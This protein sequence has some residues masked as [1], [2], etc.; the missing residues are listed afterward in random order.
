[1]PMVYIVDDEPHIRR[2]AAIGLKDA[3]FDTAEFSDGATLLHAMRQA[4]PDAVLLDWMLPGQDGINVLRTIRQDSSMRPTPILMMTA[5]SDEVD[6]VLG[7]EFGADDYVTKPFS[8]KE[9][10][11]RVKAV[12][13]RNEYLNTPQ[14]D[15]LSGGGLRVDNA[16]RSVTKNGEPVEL[17]QREFDLLY[18]LM[19][20]P[21]RVFTREMLLSTVWKTEFFGDTRTVDVH[22]RYLRQKLEEEPD[23]PRLIL[24][25]RG[26]GYRFCDTT[27]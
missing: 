3:G 22:I 26:V 17:T 16:R 4:L 15:T 19:K 10:A 9:L 14:S 27:E 24:T 1:M 12:I 18:T 20:S 21:G 23:A 6:R 7:L 13:R 8:V 11:A 25:V 2:L 5:R